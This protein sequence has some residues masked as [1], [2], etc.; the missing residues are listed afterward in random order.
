MADPTDI[1][2]KDFFNKQIAAMKQERQSFIAHYRDLAEFVQPRRGR[3]FVSDRNK[4]DRR[5]SSI[6][7]SKAT[8]A[9]RTAQAG[10]FSGVASPSRPWFTIETE[11]PGLMESAGVKVYLHQVQLLLQSIFNS[12]NFYN[13]TPVMFGELILFGTGAMSQVDDF[14]DVAR[15]YT[16]TAGS[17]FIGQ[18]DKF[19]VNRF[20][21]EIELTISQMVEQFGLENVSAHVKDQWDKGNYHNWVPVNQLIEPNPNFDP[22]KLDKEFKQFRSRYWEP[23]ED[24]DATKSKFLSK[25]GFDE[26]PVFCPRWS[27]TAEDIYGTDCP[28]MTALGDIK[29]LQIEERRKAQAIDKMVSPPLHGPASVRN[30]PVQ[31]LAGG[32]T[33]YDG[34]DQ[35]GLEPIYQVDPRLTELREDM[36][37]VENRIDTAFFV[38]LFL[39]IS[40]MEGIQPRNELEL[41][42]RNQERLLQLGPVL[43]RLQ[44]EFLSQV[45]DRTFNQAA[46]A[47]ILPESPPE[48]EGQELKIRYVSALAQAQRAVA[49][50]GI[51]RTAAFVSSLAEIWP[52]AP[53]KFNVDQAIDEYAQLTGA[54]PTV[55]NDDDTVAG[56]REQRQQQLAQ[57]QALQAAEMAAGAVKDAGSVNLD[58]NNIV[59]QVADTIQG[60]NN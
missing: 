34:G 25:G 59:S 54:I 56:I 35:R 19:R 57:Q 52:D 26:F 36:A 9:H 11:D 44:N 33:I 18:D 16:H 46:R 58:E 5:H 17:Y 1:N 32:L 60:N 55:V 22:T 2:S 4:G 13:M 51:E 3:W 38:D 30:V 23:G 45:I 42:Q 31:S 48:L 40:N 41:S 50:G 20:A 37:A 21:R 29:G 6:I 28:G 53:D 10:L 7:N 14:E 43:E 12:S 24:G 15:F 8:Q 27:V 39:A 49:T 47:N